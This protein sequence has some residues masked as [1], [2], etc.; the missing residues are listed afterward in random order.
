MAAAG[1]AAIKVASN[2]DAGPVFSD[3]V[4]TAIVAAARAAGLPVVAHTEGTGEALRVARLGATR[5]AHAPFS[6][7][8]SAEEIAELA[9]L[10]SWCS[11]LDIHGWG[12]PIREHAIAV[13]NISAF[14]RAGG[15]LRYGTDMGNGPT[16]I[17]L[18][19][20]E[21]AGLTAAGLTT[22]QQL[23]ALTPGDP[24]SPN[25]T[26]LWVPRDAQGDLNLAA[27]SPLSHVL[28]HG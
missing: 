13:R 19:P 24:R 26:L 27:A 14:V 3:D 6:E 23:T 28:A 4:F 8:L 17:G 7:L 5:L 18:N 11:T 22:E 20:R 16:A 1:A 9:A 10:T 15:R 25:T 2:K 12:T 21:L